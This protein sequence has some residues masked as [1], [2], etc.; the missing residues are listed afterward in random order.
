MTHDELTGKVSD[1][2]PPLANSYGELIVYLET[3]ALADVVKARRTSK[4]LIVTA[5]VK[6]HEKTGEATGEVEVKAA[7]AVLLGGPTNVDTDLRRM[8][9]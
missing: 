5:T 8:G 6:Q 4:R 3:A 9:C 7:R 1:L 2:L